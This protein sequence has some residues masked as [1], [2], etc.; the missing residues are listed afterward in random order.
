M[1]QKKL[2]TSQIK[3]VAMKKA[4][5]ENVINQAKAA[6]SELQAII[7]LCATELGIDVKAGK[8]RL[9][10]SGE[11]FEKVEGENELS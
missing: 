7:N 1:E 2:L 10:E 11:C 3:L 8:W 4:I 9:S 5:A 6:T